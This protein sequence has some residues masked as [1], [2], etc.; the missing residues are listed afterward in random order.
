MYIQNI[1]YNLQYRPYQKVANAKITR[2]FR[3]FQFNKP[4]K[5]QYVFPSLIP[6]L[7]PNEI[8][9]GRCPHRDLHEQN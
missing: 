4:I 2:K 5:S 7:C 1:F 9:I 6:S 3:V 8:I